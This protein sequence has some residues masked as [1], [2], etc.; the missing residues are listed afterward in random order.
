MK[1]S[2]EMLN[3]I[4]DILLQSDVMEIKSLGKTIEVF[5][6]TRCFANKDCL[7]M[8]RDAD[9]ASVKIDE[10]KEVEVKMV[11]ES[12]KLTKTK[13]GYTLENNRVYEGFRTPY[14]KSVLYLSNNEKGEP[15]KGELEI[16][17]HVGSKFVFDIVSNKKGEKKVKLKKSSEVKEK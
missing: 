13:T 7:L 4:K 10:R 6:P 5:Q 3:K 12:L 16:F 17:G 11:S 9:E 1:E 2:K 15:C 14:P 8:T